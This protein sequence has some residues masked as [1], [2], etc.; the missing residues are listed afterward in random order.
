MR[1]FEGAITTHQAQAG[2]LRSE[3]AEHMRTGL[4]ELMF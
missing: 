1:E 3:V 2:T 4:C